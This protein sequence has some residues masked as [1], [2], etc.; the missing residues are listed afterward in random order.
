[1]TAYLGPLPCAPRAVRASLALRSEATAA[2]GVHRVI[3]QSLGRLGLG[4][5]HGAL[6]WALTLIVLLPLAEVFLRKTVHGS[7]SGVHGFVQHLTLVVGRLGAAVA[8]R[9]GRLLALSTTG[10]LTNH[11]GAGIARGFA[12][13]VGAAV[14]AYLLLASIRFVLLERDAGQILAYGIPHWIFIAAMPIGFALVALRL[15]NGAATSR[16]ARLGLTAVVGFLVLLAAVPPVPPG[17]LVVP[18]LG[19][20]LV[21][22]LLGMPIFAVLGGIALVLFRATEVPIAAVS[23]EHYRL[24]TNP[25]LPALPLFTLT[26]YFLAE[27][28]ASQRLIALF[29][30]L[31]GRLRGG[32]GILTALVCA[33]FTSFTGASGVTI[34]ALGGL[35]M[36]VLTSARYSER[37]SLG[38]LTGTGSLGLLLPPCLPLL[39]Y[40]VIA[41]VS[42]TDMF[43]GGLLPG[44]LLIAMVG[45]W[46]WWRA[47]ETGPTEAP[48]ELRAA[49]HAIWEAKWE[50]LI[51][52]V[53][54]GSLFS[55]L[56]TAVE[57]AALTAFYTFVVET[58]V[59]R[60]LC[61]TR[62]VPRAMLECA[63]LIGALLLILG[64]ALGFTNYLV[65]AQIP[66]RAVEWVTS[67]IRSPLVFLLFLNLFLLAVGMLMDIY[68]ALV[69]VVP[70]I[71][72]IG[73][74]FGIDP[75]HLGIVFLA[76]AELG[77]LTPPIGPNLFMAALRFEKPVPTVFRAALPMVALFAIGVLLVTYIPALTTWLPS[78]LGQ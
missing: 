70:L 73:A 27:S 14:A 42:I 72:P 48:F 53:A 35:L 10:L 28:H 6:L 29:Q 9:R 65:D 41:Q 52:V 51:P 22:T 68:S 44:L 30:A 71:V 19:L 74:A 5:E 15:V 21:A 47:P 45:V 46:A 34:I 13:A 77:Y 36:P 64:V 66:M 69:I 17:E 59:H 62:D 26:G 76:N 50:L 61:I 55:G 43:L 75:V 60:D 40:A 20:L 18:V 11:R 56:A 23:V 24:A 1:V 2:R 12:A 16:A 67:T 63:T 25:T 8:A 57:A 3:L 78:L 31:V 37:T 32:A 4:L 33:F 49:C 58:F 39:L 7:I 54:L 38:L